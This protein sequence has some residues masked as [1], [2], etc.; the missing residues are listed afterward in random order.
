MTIAYKSLS[1]QLED[2]YYSITSLYALII[3]GY[4]GFTGC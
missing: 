2:N 4:N 1:G 3:T